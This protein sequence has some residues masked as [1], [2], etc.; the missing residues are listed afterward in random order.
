MMTTQEARAEADLRHLIDKL[1]EAIRA[2]DIDGLK[3]CFAEDAVSF[4]V[5]PRLQDVGVTAKLHNWQK[6][7]AVLQPPF[8]YEIRDLTLTIGKDVAFAH[9]INRFTGTSNGNRFGPWVRWTAGFRKSEGGWL[10]A[11]DH[12]SRPVD[13]GSGQPVLGA[14]KRQAS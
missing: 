3:G 9:G 4:D 14:M 5:G 7:F 12:V 8:G 1:V 6:A 13:L 10:I 11:H 2:M